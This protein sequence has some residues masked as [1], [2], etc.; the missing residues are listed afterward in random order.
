MEQGIE[1]QGST[2]QELKAVVTQEVAKWAEVIKAGNIQP[3]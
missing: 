2:P 1:V 3:E